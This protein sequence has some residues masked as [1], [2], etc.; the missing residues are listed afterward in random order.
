MYRLFNSWPYLLALALAIPFA[1]FSCGYDFIGGCSSGVSLSINGTSDRFNLSERSA[2][3]RAFPNP[4]EQ[5][6]PIFVSGY[7]SPSDKQLFYTWINP[8]GCSLAKQ[9]IESVS[10]LIT[11][12]TLSLSK[13]LWLLRLEDNQT[14]VFLPVFVF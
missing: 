2:K 7:R 8:E 1:G 12:Q 6:Q 4:A 5:G 11:L 10:S 3:P 14:V 9:Q 13:G